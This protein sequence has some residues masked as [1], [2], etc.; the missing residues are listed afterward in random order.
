MEINEKKT[1]TV[2]SDDHI[3]G[4][5]SRGTQGISFVCSLWLT[6]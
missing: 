3:K 4:G 5:V 2:S 1:R 6:K